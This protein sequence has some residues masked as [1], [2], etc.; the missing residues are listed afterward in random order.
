MRAGAVVAVRYDGARKVLE[1][2]QRNGRVRRI[3][4]SDLP[5]LD[6]VP[7]TIVR[8]VAVSPA[9]DAISWR[10][11]DVDLSVRGLLEHARRSCGVDFD[12]GGGQTT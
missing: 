2:T 12:A 5:G 1:L 10:E 9:G 8:S 4:C 7:V 6:G 3:Q 11:L